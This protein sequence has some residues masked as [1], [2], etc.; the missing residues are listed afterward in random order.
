MGCPGGVEVVAH[1]LRNVLE[2]PADSDEA[3]L[4]IDFRNAFNLIDRDA[5]VQAACRDF[6][7]MS[8][9]TQWCYGSPSVLLYDHHRVIQSTCGV[10]QGD[11][12]GPLYFCCGI[13]GLVEKIQKFGPRYNKWYMD[14][15]GIIAP[16]G[17]LVAIWNMLLEES[18]KLGL[19][20]NPAKCEWSWLNPDCTQPC[21]IRIPGNESEQ[22]QVVP[23]DEIQM[24]GVPLGSDGKAAAY[25][26]KKL[27]GKLAGV[28]NKL[29]D[30]DDMQ[31]AFFLLR[32]SF[33][34]VRA[35][36]FM[37]TT[38]L[39][40]W[41]RQAEKFDSEI[42]DAAQSILGLTMSEQ[43]WKQACLTPRLGGLGLR[44]V[45]DHAEIAFSA[46]WWEAKATCGEDWSERKDVPWKTTQKQGSFEKDKEIMKSL[47][48]QAASQRER[49]RLGRLQC[50]H[51]GAWICAVPS[52]LDG[53]D[54][55]MRP[56]N[57][58]VA[59]SMRLGLPVLLE[60]KSCSLCMQIIDVYG[61]HAACC[62]VSSDR[63]HRHNRV[64]NLVDRIAQEGML[65]PIMEK[66]HILGDVDGRRPGDVSLPLWRANKGLAI[67][68]AV[69]CPLASSYLNDPKHCETYAEFK[70][71]AYYDEGFKGTRFEFAAMVFETTGGTNEEGLEVLRQ[72]FRFAAKHQNVQLS[73]YC[74]RAWARLACN[75]QSSVSQ[76]FLNR[77]GSLAAVEKEIDFITL[78]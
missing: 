39:A 45:V 22:I 66:K 78:F 72:L 37:R 11:P 34:I 49:Q 46:S 21:P 50:E 52:T 35:N 16:V 65:S 60:E 61:D 62:S 73:V 51:S 10:Q 15:G 43:S 69:T 53:N 42:W 27:L 56:R 18:P 32:T 14:D 55:V 75:I 48:Q 30:F 38:P 19:E 29:A 40:K 59:V 2:G 33:N 36:H 58:Q 47:V 28:V 4:K 41:R 8:L 54:T 6:P 5:F 74:G 63:I 24:L 23:T 67:D 76:C 25:V 57:F 26:E 71:H 1:S 44:K 12:L 13:A 3:L 31:S 70:K 77:A 64:R 68:V 20:L 7:G 17:K 9:W